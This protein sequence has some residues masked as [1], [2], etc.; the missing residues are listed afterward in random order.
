MRYKQPKKT[1]TAKIYLSRVFYNFKYV[2]N[3]QLPTIFYK[4]LRKSYFLLSKKKNILKYFYFLARKRLLA[5][6]A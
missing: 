5:T 2:S 3:M 6:L 4:I 1:Q